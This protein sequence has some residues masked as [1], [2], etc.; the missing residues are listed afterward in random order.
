MD[1]DKPVSPPPMPDV[2]LAIPRGDEGRQRSL[3]DVESE[4]Y[5][6]K[7]R[8]RTMEKELLNLQ[9][10]SSQF[11]RRSSSLRAMLTVPVRPINEELQVR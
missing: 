4:N 10:L 5:I 6:L 9:D 2:S 1:R 8:I 3:E 11:R 7:E